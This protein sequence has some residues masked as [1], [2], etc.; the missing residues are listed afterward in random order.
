MRFVLRQVV[1]NFNERNSNVYIASLYA[2]KAFAR[3]NHYKL[4]STLISHNLAKLFCKANY[5]LVFK[6]VCLY[7]MKRF[8]F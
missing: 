1:N 5:Q 4:F 2:S 3:V 6:D 7:K 8:L